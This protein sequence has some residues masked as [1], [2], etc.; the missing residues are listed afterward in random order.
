MS[1]QYRDQ[2][3]IDNIRKRIREIR[4]IKG[5]VQEDIVDRTGF[6]IAQIGRI[7]R[8]ISNT[9]ISNIAAIARALEV[10]PRE[11]LDFEFEIP[12]YPPLRKDRKAKK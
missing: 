11:L 2:E 3:F 9:S 1:E 7:E 6:N 5:I 10:H 4:E 8:G 12:N